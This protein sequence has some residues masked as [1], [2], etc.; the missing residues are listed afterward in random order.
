MTRQ[1]PSP[2]AI[3]HGLLLRGSGV[4]C[5]ILALPVKCYMLHSSTI[6]GSHA[7]CCC[8]LP[9]ACR[10]DIGKSETWGSKLGS[11]RDRLLT[12]LS[13]GHKWEVSG[14]V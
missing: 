7:A 2:P 3:A 11:D 13:C 1:A 4:L 8:P 5:E 12:C 10:R 14:L 9:H 6:Q